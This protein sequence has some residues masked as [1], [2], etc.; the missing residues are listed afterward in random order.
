M[1]T[2]KEWRAHSGR[3]RRERSP[4]RPS[5][6]DGDLRKTFPVGTGILTQKMLKWT[7]ANWAW[8]AGLKVRGRANSALSLF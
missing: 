4:G 8:W 1:E 7:A 2:G 5:S 3:I 6:D